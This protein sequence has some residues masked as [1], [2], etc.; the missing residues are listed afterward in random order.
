MTA[1]KLEPF[2]LERLQST[3]EHQVDFN[4]SESGVQPLTLGELVEDPAA[5]DALLAE[6]VLHTDERHGGVARR[7][8]RRTTRA[9]RPT[10][11]SVTNGG[12]EANYITTWNLVE[13]GD[14]VVM[15]VP[16]FMQTWGLAR[17]FGAVTT[18]MAPHRALR[19]G[20][21]SRR[22]ANRHRRPRAPDVVAHEADRDLQSQ[23]SDRHALRVRRPRSPRRHRRSARQLDPVGRDLPWRRARRSRNADALGSRSERVLVTGGLS[24]AYGL[25]GLRIGW[26]VGPPARIASLWSFHDYTTIAPERVER[27]AGTARARAGSGA[28]VLLARTRNVLNRNYPVI[29]SWLDERG[30]LFSYVP[31]DAGAMIVRP[32]SSRDQLQ[33]HSSPGCEWRRASS[34][35][36]AIIS[37]W[38]ATCASASVTRR[39]GCRRL[40]IG[41]SE[42]LIHSMESRIADCGSDRSRRQGYGLTFELA[43]GRPRQCRAPFRR[44]ARSNNPPCAR[45]SSA[46]P[47]ATMRLRRLERIGRSHRPST[48]EFIRDGGEGARAARAGRTPRGRRDDDAGHRARRT[49][50]QPRPGRARRRRSCGHGQQ[51]A[52]G[53]CLPSVGACS[54]RVRSRSFLFEGAVMDGSADLQPGTRTLPAVTILG[55]RGVVNSTTNFII[56]AM[57]QGQRFED[58]LSEMQARGVAEAD[59]SLD[60]DGWDAAA[61][62]AAL[63][64]VLL[65]ANITPQAGRSSRDRS[66]HRTRPLRGRGPTGRRLKL[67]ARADATAVAS[68]RRVAP[69]ELSERRSARRAGRPA[70]RAHP[71]DGP[72]RGNRRRAAKRQ[73]DAD[74]LR[75][76]LR[77]HAPS[78]KASWR[79]RHPA[80]ACCSAAASKPLTTWSPMMVT[81]MVRHPRAMRS[82][83][84]LVVFVDVVCRERHAGL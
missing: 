8:S 5:R 76:A 36:P 7:S 81:G 82:S 59:A 42:G 12:A 73:P 22:M 51:G 46:S 19:C 34:W 13:P 74:G 75:P 60:V 3:F 41:V 24:K 2:E 44:D 32:L 33:R 57:E 47:R 49:G 26:I 17:A 28:G 40:W 15:M 23:Q 64:N 84:A 29:A 35:C 11:C 39:T 61:K 54:R 25:P 55:F 38:T 20:A 21:R 14:E 6:P 66:G 27:C 31:P 30:D 68:P 53:V 45:P 83:Y 77:P 63:A 67:V 16:N 4:L 43:A 62:T 65:G 79:A 56:T 72:A 52:G 37:G 1:V 9:R 80:I 78:R 48:L 69:E 71:A 70:E 58:A 50:N 18:G 10:T